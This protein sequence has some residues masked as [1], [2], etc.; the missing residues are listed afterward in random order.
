MGTGPSKPLARERTEARNRLRNAGRRVS[1]EHWVQG[2]PL[3]AV[4]SGLAA[5][6]ALAG[7]PR[8][9]VLLTRLFR[10]LMV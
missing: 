10:R 4:S 2:H 5:G 7:I 8:I 9:L 1:L 6:Y 3:T